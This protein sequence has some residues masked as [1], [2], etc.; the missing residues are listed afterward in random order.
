MVLYHVIISTETEIIPVYFIILFYHFGFQELLYSF[1][2]KKM[3]TI[4]QIVFTAV[5]L[6]LGLLCLLYGIT[7]FLVQSGSKFYVVWF[8]GF[9]FFLLLSAMTFFRLFGKIPLPVRIIGIGILT[10]G[11]LYFL[12]TQF[13]ILNHFADR[14]PDHL[15]YLLVLGA[16]VHK[17][18]PSVVLQYRLDTA[19]EYLNA[20]PDTVCIVSGGQGE[21]EP[22]PEAEGMKKYLVEKQISPDRIILENKSRNTIENI[23][24]SKELLK[25]ENCTVGIL[26]NNFHTYRSVALGKKQLKNPIYGI[27]APSN[28]R[29]LPNN[30]LRETVGI[31]KDVLLGNMSF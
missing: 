11:F 2:E 10:L 9:V 22:M 5:F 8:A 30:M 3:F 27:A 13:L 23:L 28:P 17:D 16:Q 20:N 12:F 6:L 18:R 24:F 21:N 19:V 26:T 14:A 4:P 15:D 29:Y 1:M 25:N 7:V 31:T